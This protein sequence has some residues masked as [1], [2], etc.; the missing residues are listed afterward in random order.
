[1]LDLRQ[2]STY[3]ARSLGRIRTISVHHWS[4]TYNLSLG[5]TEEEEIEAIEQVRAF[6]KNTRGWPD[7]AYHFTVALSG[8]CYYTGDVTTKRYVVGNDTGNLETI[9]VALVGNFMD[10]PPEAIQLDAVAQLIA[11]LQYDFEG[12]LSVVP[13][14]FYSSTECP[15][16]TWD[17]WKGYIDGSDSGINR[18]NVLSTTAEISTP[19]PDS[20][21]VQ[22]SLSANSAE[23]LLAQFPYPGSFRD[24][25]DEH[26]WTF[27]WARCMQETAG[28]SE[29]LE[30]AFVY[31]TLGYTESKW[32]HNK[33]ALG[34]EPSYGIF[35]RHLYGSAST[36]R[37]KYGTAKTIEMLTDP[38]LD[39]Q[40]DWVHDE[41]DKAFDR[42][43]SAG[44]RGPELAM[45][46][47][48]DAER[49]VA[50]AE[51]KY[52]NDWAYLRSQVEW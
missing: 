37:Q 24:S 52:R 31:F 8:R 35:M 27:G 17:Q 21:V 7:Y 23:V 45:L 47:G 32:V 12:T 2:Q 44:F 38:S 13:H 43:W 3:Q 20:E 41:V 48:R 36:M 18:S 4:G 39:H 34:D 33:K 51:V 5:S 16:D 1:M 26:A 19:L 29:R 9:S 30:R 25:I 49:P 28:L 46:V 11:E 10:Y 42:Y 50:G 14:H 40:F 22:P 15:G 6:H